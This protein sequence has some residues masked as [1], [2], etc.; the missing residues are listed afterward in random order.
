MSIYIYFFVSADACTLEPR[1][2]HALGPRPTVSVRRLSCVISLILSHSTVQTM[3]PRERLAI[4][5]VLLAGRCATGFSPSLLAR[6]V[7]HHC[8][9]SSRRA[10]QCL[11]PLHL[12]PPDDGDSDGDEALDFDD[13]DFFADDGNGPIGGS[14]F[15]DFEDAEA[16]AALTDT[17]TSTLPIT[18]ADLS[19][20]DL[21]LF[22]L[23]GDVLLDSY[24]GSMGFD[25]VTDWDYYQVDED[26]N[27]GSRVRPNP[28]DAGQPRRTR[29][30]SGSVVRIFRGEL[31]G[32]LGA[33][34]RS[35][36]MDKRVLVKEFSGKVARDLAASEL[37]A[38]GTLQSA[39]CSELDEGARSGEWSATAATRYLA[40]KMN[41]STV[42][43]DTNLVKLM[44]ILGV[45]K[46]NVRDV[47]APFVGILGRLDLQDFE[48][49][50]G[51]TPQ[52][53]YT[54]LKVAPP[55]KDSVWLVYEYV[56]LTTLNTY[57][58]PP[59]VRMQNLPPQRGFF[60]NPIAPP[61]L[62]QWRER[63]NYVVKGIMKQCLEGLAMLHENGIAHRSIG[64]NSV[65]LSSVAQDKIEASSPYAIV[66]SRLVVKL[67]DFG[68]GGPISESA[69]D[70]GFRQRAK[71]FG[72]DVREGSSS[73]AATNFAMAEDL[74]ALGFVFL[75]TLLTS[76]AEIPTP[77]YKMP[78]TDEDSLQRLV[79]EIFEKEMDEFREYCSAEDFWSKL[80]NL[81]DENDGAGW[82]LL[83]EMCFARERAAE[84]KEEFSVLT[85]RGLLSNKLFS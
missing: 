82:S 24:A 10:P 17:Q 45:G 67:A 29:A 35:R 69:L 43:D 2:E 1:L 9:P 65:I 57:A 41:G 51:I 47:K 48:E 14:V 31:T 33:S 15:E 59:I 75:G 61:A 13:D 54:A 37:A 62:P 11:L 21:R 49:D 16:I 5:F 66:P 18:S 77:G 50:E 79:T 27:R 30:S 71:G 80:V 40:G 36:G 20:T 23:G 85:A 53:W 58:M 52:E 70:E 8:P 46:S 25:E 74:H 84:N 38:V 34:L 60:G 3:R 78:D 42:K 32:K 7:P 76:L 28:F 72:I 73:V 39:V 19:G 44:S 22:C 6:V 64:R 81:L 63:S 26:G 56:G 4:A 83:R 68:F 55:K 12:S